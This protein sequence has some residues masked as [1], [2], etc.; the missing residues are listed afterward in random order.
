MTKN[1]K[2]I[3]KFIALTISL[4]LGISNPI[5]AAEIKSVSTNNCTENSDS[6]RNIIDVD[7]EGSLKVA[8]IRLSKTHEDSEIVLTK[9]LYIR[10]SITIDI[11]ANI[12]LNGFRIE[13]LN[14]KSQINVGKKTLEESIP[15]QVYHEGHWEKKAKT[16]RTHSSSVNN[17]FYYPNNSVNNTTTYKT[18]YENVWVP[19]YYTTSYKD[20]YKWH[21][22]IRVNI[23]NGSI[24][25]S[26]APSG[27]SKFDAYWIRDAHGDPGSSAEDVFN[28]ISGNLKLT[29][30]NVKGGDGGNGGDATY[31]DV[32]HVPV[33]GGGN[34][35]KGGNGG[36]GASIFKSDHGTVA[37]SKDSTLVPGSYGKGGKGGEPNPNYWIIPGKKGKD[38]KCGSSGLY[39]NDKNKLMYF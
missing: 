28:L 5:W 37:V 10:D 15:Y 39:I 3:Y 17:Y 36:N 21:D 29:K 4:T 11:D 20:V 27:A 26:S 1:R 18:E 33:F 16:S 2:S 25:Q 38:G 23:Y 22:D 24:V 6:S 12:N 7:S 31:S 13:I 9:N 30:V 34:G 35:G 32:W 14:S 19:G 8:L